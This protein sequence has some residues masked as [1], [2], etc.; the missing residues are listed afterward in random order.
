MSASYPVHQK[1]PDEAGILVVANNQPAKP[2]KAWHYLGETADLFWRHTLGR[3]SCA[4]RTPFYF[5]VAAARFLMA[6]GKG[7]I[8]GAALGIKNAVQYFNP[9]ALEHTSWPERWLSSSKHNF[10]RTAIL[11][12][13][14]VASTLGIVF[15]PSK[16]YHSLWEAAKLMVSSNPIRLE[17]AK[18]QD[19]ETAFDTEIYNERLDRAFQ[20]YAQY[21]PQYH[22]MIFGLLGRYSAGDFYMYS[23][24]CGSL[25]NYCCKDI[26]DGQVD[27]SALELAA[28]Q[29]RDDVSPI[30]LASLQK[31]L[32]RAC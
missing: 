28:D 29:Q 30:S 16:G 1:M 13:R 23:N 8:G 22:K 18:L 12:D 5:I 32:I 31:A 7:V 17:G 2:S 19:P 24:S 27:E 21:R 15:A 26:A 25:F 11:L 9:E 6:C 3:V 4:I 20:T 14:S 10:M